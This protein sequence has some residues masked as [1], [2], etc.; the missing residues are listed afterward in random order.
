M[1]ERPE[2]HFRRALGHFCTG[3]TVIA[4]MGDEEPVGFACQSFAALSLDPPLVLFCPGKSSRTWPVIEAA[5]GVLRQRPGA[6]PARRERGV[7]P[8]RR[9][10]VRRG[11]LVARAVGRADPRRRAHL[12]R[13][14]RRAASST[15]ATTGSSSAGCARSADPADERPL[16]FYRGAYAA[17]EKPEPT[18]GHPRQPD[19]LVAR[20][21]LVLTPAARLSRR[22]QPARPTRSA[23][24]AV[25]RPARTS[26]Q[27]GERLVVK[28]SS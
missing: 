11:G 7:R 10:Q 17:T 9:R 12:D 28:Q 16:L 19:H 22:Q 18:P 21:R 25:P 27:L 8:G 24:S 3:V 23:Q 2:P 20:R 13:L 26:Y 1:V 6:R 4:A 14:H 15:A 5:G